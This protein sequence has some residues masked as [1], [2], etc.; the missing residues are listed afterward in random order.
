VPTPEEARLT[1]LLD[2]VDLASTSTK[3]FDDTKQYLAELFGL[4]PEEIYMAGASTRA[5]NLNI[6]MGQGKMIQNHFPLGVG[7]LGAENPEGAIPGTRGYVGKGKSYD[8]IAIPFKKDGVWTVP[9]II[10]APGG[11]WEPRF[12]AAFPGVKRYDPEPE[13]GV[14]D[15]TLPLGQSQT[16]GAAV[17][18]T[19]GAGDISALVTAWTAQLASAGFVVTHDVAR[20][21]ALSLMAKRLVMLTGLSGSGKTLLARAF[22]HWLTASAD[23]RTVVAVGADWTTR[24]A[25][26][27]YR[28]ALDPARYET[29]DA[30]NLILRA[31]ANPGEPHFL[32]LDEM[33]LSHVERY[34]SDFLSAMES[35]E[36]LM[37]HSADGD[38]M[39]V[40]PMIS[41]LPD[42][43]FVIGTVNIDETT[44]MF[45]PKVLDRANVIEFRASEA[46]LQDYLASP[47]RVD[48]TGLDGQGVQFAPA[49]VRAAQ[50]ELAIDAL[51]D[52]FRRLAAEEALLLFRVL[53]DFGMEF[54]PRTV[55][56]M[57]RYMTLAMKERD[58]G[59]DEA[60]SDILREALDVQVLQKILPRLNGSRSRLEPVLRSMAVYCS[61]AHEWDSGSIAN[62]E[63]LLESAAAAEEEVS[64]E[65]STA[66][67]LFLPLSHAKL[68]R[69]FRRLV[70]DGFVNFAEA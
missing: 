22:A 17:T 47:K 35:G 13:V 43:L 61:T 26:L 48:V 10:E 52:P 67:T 65:L 23:Q 55:H 68:S 37:L 34:F 9:A 50:A 42:N 3:K 63:A 11:R 19:G 32:V 6:R 7:V 12:R 41:N 15:L 28:D 1:E 70:Q 31:A 24:D 58:P 40:P 51:V 60:R 59:A 33:N 62:T 56:E 39:G 14:V 8:A 36:P 49:F 30:L 27:G 38:V 29:T 18:S 66:V 25:L 69:M 44:Y 16:G 21:L 53:A 57:L 64:D 5:G 45:S 4:K 54:G 2:V 46:S 20:R